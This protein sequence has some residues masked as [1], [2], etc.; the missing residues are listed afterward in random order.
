MLFK[1]VARGGGSL[2]RKGEGTRHCPIEPT[3]RIFHTNLLS[4]EEGPGVTTVTS[5]TYGPFP[6]P[7]TLPVIIYTQADT[8]VTDDRELPI[9]NLLYSKRFSTI[10]RFF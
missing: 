3:D 9:D 6:H 1:F 5:R 10:N 8:G 4:A 7:L 2:E